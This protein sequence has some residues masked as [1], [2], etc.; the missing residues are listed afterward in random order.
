[1][2][3]TALITKARKM[4]ADMIFLE[5]NKKLEKAMNLYKQLGFELVEFNDVSKYA[6]STIKMELKLK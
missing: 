6:R 3:A 5:T 2:L 1:M 4:K